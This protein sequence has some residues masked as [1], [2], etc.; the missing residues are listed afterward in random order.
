[1]SAH[2]TPVIAD[3]AATAAL[4][5][6]LS[7]QDK[8]AAVGRID[9]DSDGW[10][11]LVAEA[12]R[13]GVAPLAYAGLGAAGPSTGVPERAL[14]RLKGYFLQTGLRN[15]RLFG[16][17]GPVLQCLAA[18]AIDAIVLKGAFVAE[19]VYGNPA[20]RTMS[21]AD[22]LVRRADLERVKRLLHAQR[23]RQEAP[24]RD[25]SRES[26]GHQ[27]PT[28]VRDG[29]QIEI[30]WSI[31]DDESPFTI[32]NEGLWQRACK[33]SVAGAPAFALAP[34]DLLLHLCLHTSYSHGWL[35]FSGGLRH[36]CDI[37]STVR[38]Y[39]RRFDWDAF[40]QRANAWGIAN[41]V[42]L[43][44]V[45]ARDLLAAAVPEEALGRLAPRDIDAG[46]VKTAR[47]LTLGAHY[48]KLTNAL[49]VLARAWLTKRWGHLSGAARW[50][51]QLL[52]GRESQ[53]AAYPSLR[54]TGLIPMRYL[55][56]WTDLARDCAS[57]VLVR[58]TRMLL[59]RER[60]RGALLRW[61]ECSGMTTPA[62]G[63]VSYRE[64]TIEDSFAAARVN[65]QSWTESFAAIRPQSALGNMSVE[66][67]AALFRRRFAADLYKMFVAE[68]P[69][70]GVIG[71]VDVGRARE[72]CWG[73][74]VELY[75]LYILK[76]FQRKGIGRRLFDLAAG[77][78]ASKG[79]NSLYLI[80]LQDSP[81]KPFY[82]RMGGRRLAER[83]SGATAGEDAHI[84]Y[85][86]DNLRASVSTRGVQVSVVSRPA[87]RGRKP[88]E[89]D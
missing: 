26:L 45:L 57:I 85:A 49:P 42:W 86:W 2:A 38:C 71:F 79:M 14:Q 17:L 59:A 33:A 31:E 56:H 63:N 25:A 34:E 35:Q 69:R 7:A 70:Q 28:F 30:H 36:L 52:P 3:D 9:L 53:A 29:V 54:A 11:A 72:N 83:S 77:A 65:V 84:I 68:V 23:W 15:L 27:L 82:E 20:L 22:V 44:L 21:D 40:A 51:E 50:R 46:V 74:D 47:D 10:D 5:T 13:H 8:R 55:A 67:R 62:S 18:E 87:R 43:T 16:R 80:V 64:A 76:E 12:V 32:D 48:A 75:A 4:L 58:D 61:L 88:S 24:P 39:E 6:I 73:C 66:Q 81:Y 19:A 1:M 37:A 89:I 78:V 60:A 41:C